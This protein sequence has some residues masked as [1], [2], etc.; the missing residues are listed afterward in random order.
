MTHLIS[1][2]YNPRVM[3]EPNKQDNSPQQ[4]YMLTL[5]S[6]AGQV[7]LLTLGIIFVALFAGLW[8]D[9]EVGTKP[10][11]TIILLVASVPVTV[12]IMFR[13]VRSATNRINPVE[14]KETP[15]E[16]QNSGKNS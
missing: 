7:G 16:E 3:S 1:L 2:C 12:Y 9:G 13:V 4:S 8:L 6:I 5:A 10:L 15:E 14:I 11:F